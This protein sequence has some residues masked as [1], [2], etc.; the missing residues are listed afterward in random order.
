M[1]LINKI[2]CFKYK[3]HFLQKENSQNVSILNK[4]LEKQKYFEIKKVMEA[5]E[6][7]RRMDHLRQFPR[8]IP[9]Q[10]FN[11]EKISGYYDKRLESFQNFVENTVVKANGNIY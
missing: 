6:A 4:V 5:Q 1:N 8:N 7:I 10:K 11:L 3:N 2:I 9:S